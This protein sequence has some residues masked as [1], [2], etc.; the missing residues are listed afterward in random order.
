MPFTMAKPLSATPL[1]SSF[2]PPFLRKRILTPN[3][4]P[5]RSK[6]FPEKTGRG[7]GREGGQGRGRR[8]PLPWFLIGLE[9]R[10]PTHTALLG[11][12]KSMKEDEVNEGTTH[13]LVAVDINPNRSCRAPRH[14]KPWPG[15]EA[16]SPLPAGCDAFCSPPFTHETVSGIGGRG[17]GACSP[18]DILVPCAAWLCP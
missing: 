12:R 13:P 16:E 5:V 7:G 6:L 15:A 2:D 18:K 1:S 4:P 14:V 17:E 3:D 8:S 9:G 10:S 11:S